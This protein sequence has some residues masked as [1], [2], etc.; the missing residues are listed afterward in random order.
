MADRE[1]EQDRRIEELERKVA[2][3]MRRLGAEGEFGATAVGAEAEVE[4]LIRAGRK[5]EA[6]KRWRESTGQGLLE[7][8]QAIEALERRLR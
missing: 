4:S 7:A 6:I 2:F 1:Q 5:I 8:K 3:L